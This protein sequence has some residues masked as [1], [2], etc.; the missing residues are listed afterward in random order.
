MIGI[1]IIVFLAAFVTPYTAEITTTP[2]ENSECTHTTITLWFGA[3]QTFDGEVCEN[4]S[5]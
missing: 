2:I 4:A 1:F 5:P 3:I